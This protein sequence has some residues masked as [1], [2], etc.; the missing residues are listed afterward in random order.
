MERVDIRERE[1]WGGEGNKEVQN[2]AK[3]G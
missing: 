1:R 3:T 2:Y